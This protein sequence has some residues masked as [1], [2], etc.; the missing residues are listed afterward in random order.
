MTDAQFRRRKLHGVPTA[1]RGQFDHELRKP[2]SD[3]PVRVAEITETEDGLLRRRGDFP[4]GFD[5][6]EYDRTTQMVRCMLNGAPHRTDGAAVTGV[7]GE[8]QWRSYWLHGREVSKMTVWRKMAVDPV[9][10]DEAVK[11]GWEIAE[12][13]FRDA[14][15]QGFGEAA[16]ALERMLELPGTDEDMRSDPDSAAFLLGQREAALRLRRQWMMAIFEG[17]DIEPMD[18][19]LEQLLDEARQG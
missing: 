6:V 12:D 14:M 1:V 19:E 8:D 3:L 18:V 5:E 13:T 9:A 2:A 10:F 15:R 17:D 11:E 4:G 16:E 7:E